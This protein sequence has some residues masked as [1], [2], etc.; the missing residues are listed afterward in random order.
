MESPPPPVPLGNQGARLPELQGPCK[1]FC[2][3]FLSGDATPLNPL[4][5]KKDE[6]VAF[7]TAVCESGDNGSALSQSLFHLISLAGLACLDL[8][9]WL[10]VYTHTYLCNTHTNT[11]MLFIHSCVHQ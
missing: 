10:Y 5:P 7:Y 6:K 8:L 9:R 3:P 2:D 4:A 11:Y 1:V